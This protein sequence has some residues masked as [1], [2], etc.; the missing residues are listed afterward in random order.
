MAFKL[1]EN[2]YITIF[3]RRHWF[4]PVTQT[5]M[6]LFS[7]LAPIFI[8]SLA[9]AFPNYNEYF[10]NLGLLSLIFLTAWIFI[11]W[12]AIFIVWT[13]HFLDVLV[14]TNLHIIDI[15]QVGLWNRKISTLQIK[16]VQDISSKVVGLIPSILKYGDL[17]I[18]T[19]GSINNFIIHNIQRPD[20]I[21]QKINAQITSQAN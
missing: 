21:R 19:A 11:V 14:V 4:N 10:G 6:F 2:E 13:N 16:N 5:L 7:L 12:T 9:Y 3:V 15:E 8:T 17:K 1:E 20:L 18:Q